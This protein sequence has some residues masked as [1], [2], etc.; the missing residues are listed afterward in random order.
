[1]VRIPYLECDT[2]DDR[3]PAG[4]YTTTVGI[5]V[6]QHMQGHV[7]FIP[8]PVGYGLWPEF[9]GSFGPYGSGPRRRA[10]IGQE[11]SHS[12]KLLP[13]FA[14]RS[15]LDEAT[16]A[17]LSCGVSKWIVYRK[18]CVHVYDVYIVY[19]YT[20]I[21][22]RALGMLKTA[23]NR[24]AESVLYFHEKTFGR[25]AKQTRNLVHGQFGIFTVTKR[26]AGSVL[27]FHEKRFGRHAKQTRNH[28]SR[29]GI[30]SVFS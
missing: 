30:S 26:G 28:E 8:P 19:I 1:M 18:I 24:G 25:H 2:A 16:R 22:C 4:T 17:R 3:N 14:G 13:D 7:G 10:S 23:A 29:C 9:Y 6:V 15:K 21:C 27:Y 5:T 11:L 12:F 20:Y